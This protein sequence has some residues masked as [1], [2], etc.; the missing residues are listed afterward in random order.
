MGSPAVKSPLMHFGEF[1]QPSKA[2]SGLGEAERR[3]L[4]FGIWEEEQGESPGIAA[5]S[6]PTLFCP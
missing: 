5:G 2:A 1:K 4:V 3:N 6:P